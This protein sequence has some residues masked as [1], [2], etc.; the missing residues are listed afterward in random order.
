MEVLNES[1]ERAARAARDSYGRLVALLARS[2][3]DIAAAEDALAD[4]FERA[5][6]RWPRD[7]IPDNPEAWL[8]TVARNRQRDHLR[9][10]AHRTSTVLDEAVLI[11]SHDEVDVEAIP[12]ERLALMF[13]CAH[14]AID[15]TVR[16]PLMLQTVLGVGSEQIAAAFAIPA[17]TMAQRLVRAKRR[18]RDARIPFVVPDQFAA[19]TRLPE[20]LEAV[21]G[22]YAIDWQGTAGMT[23]R[24]SLAVEA[25]QLAETLALLVPDEPEALGLASLICLSMAR[26]PA[27]VD[28]SG[29]M[30]PLPD[31]DTS[32]WDAALIERGERYLVRAHQVGRIGR[33]QLEAAIQSVHC[34]RRNTGLT[35]WQALRKFHT[36]LA[37]IAPTLGAAVSLAVVIG[38]TD[39]PTAGLAIL[40]ELD[41]PQARRF[42]PA[43]AARAHLRARAGDTLGAAEA[44]DRA[45]SL[46]TDPAT[47]AYLQRKAGEG[48]PR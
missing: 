31:Q 5:L 22:A 34:D 27:R 12:D 15:K 40:D 43:F 14:P 32:R 10:A 38:E 46:T 2:S 17:P 47:R 24:G 23:E 45:I 39:G 41:S 11:A 35:D 26:A 44:L 36:A 6:I 19:P 9:S 28:S 21:Y 8:L 29:A 37:D 4:A 42:Q 1:T 13:V 20:V 3:G 7:G 30:V 25:L 48:R 33:F 18:I 16:T